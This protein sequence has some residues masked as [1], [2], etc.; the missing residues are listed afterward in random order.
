MTPSTPAGVRDVLEP[1]LPAAPAD[2]PGHLA[3]SDH[4]PAPAPIASGSV[5]GDR[6]VLIELI[7]EGGMG[8]VYKAKHKILDKDLAVK[9]LR[10]EATRSEEAMRRFEREARAA[11][12]LNHLNLVSVYDFG[13]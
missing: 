11:N 3:C 2:R 4:H 8:T 13:V 1:T 10:T 12:S 6:Y 5:I 9:M 7:G